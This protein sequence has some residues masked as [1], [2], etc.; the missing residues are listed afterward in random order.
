MNAGSRD[1]IS[2]GPGTG[3]IRLTYPR[4]QSLGRKLLCGERSIY[5]LFEAI[6]PPTYSRD[7]EKLLGRIVSK[8]PWLLET[9]D[10]LM[11]SRIL[12][13]GLDECQHPIKSMT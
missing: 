9:A 11:V 8:T 13:S 6:H 4:E 10:S 3:T 7:G 2:I 1:F 5:I 12:L